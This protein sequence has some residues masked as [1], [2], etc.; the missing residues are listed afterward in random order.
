MPN[1]DPNYPLT[2]IKMDNKFLDLLISTNSL[3]FFY[4]SGLKNFIN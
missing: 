2:Q 4:L 1:F 3:L